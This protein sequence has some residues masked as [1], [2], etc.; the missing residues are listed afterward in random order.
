MRLQNNIR[1]VIEFVDERE[2]VNF[3][4]NISYSIVRKEIKSI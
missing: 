3:L 1:L 2:T 4:I